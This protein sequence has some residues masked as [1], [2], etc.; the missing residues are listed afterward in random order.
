MDALIE[1]DCSVLETHDM[2]VE[3]LWFN[4]L[5]KIPFPLE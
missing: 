2:D 3:R 4:I 1:E 5:G